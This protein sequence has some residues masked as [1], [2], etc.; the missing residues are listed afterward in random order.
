M[1]SIVP[2]P[3]VKRGFRT[4]V[5]G[6]RAIAV[7]LVLA[8]HAGIPGIS[9]GYVGVDIF[10]VIS[11]FLISTHLLQRLE[12]DGR[13]GF[14]D[15]YARRVRRI[16]PA[17]LTVAVLTAVA[18]MLFYPPLALE[19]VLR[20]G[21]ATI[22]YVPNLWF[23]LQNTDYL[24]DHSP[25]P[26]QHYWSL[27]VEEQFYL[28]W[29][30]LLLVLFLVLRRR[31]WAMAIGM[32]V[33]A[34][35]S[36][37][38]GVLLTGSDQPMAF[39]SLPTRAWELLL[40]G[41][42]GVLLLRGA[43]RVRAWVAALGGWLGIALMFV[44]A[45]VFDADTPFPGWAALPPTVG[46]ALVI[47]FGAEAVRA[48]PSALL[49][50]R[51]MQFLGL[52]SYSL[53]LVH[54]PLLVITQAAVGEENPLPLAQRVALGIGLAVPLAWLLFRFV[55]TP[56]R[57][58]RWL[59]GRR[60]RATLL[61]AL[62]MTVVLI[63]G[64]AVS[65]HWASVDRLGTSTAA[66]S[67]PAFPADPP[68]ATGFVPSNMRPSLAGAAAD[69]PPVFTDGCH[70]D[71]QSESVQDCVYGNPG[72]TADIALFGDS[73]TAQWFPAIRDFTRGHDQFRIRSYTKS[74]CP[75]VSVTVLVKGVPYDACN[76]WRLAVLQHLEADPPEL[77]V[78]SSY[79]HYPLAGVSDAAAGREAW[80][81]GLRQTVQRLRD[82]GSKV[83]I[84]ADTPRLPSQPP[85]CLSANIQDV[86][87]CDTQR[88]WALNAQLA[89]TEKMVAKQTG[90][91]YADLTRYICDA[92]VCPTIVDDIQV[93]RD[94][95][96]LTATFVSYIAPALAPQLTSMLDL[97]SDSAP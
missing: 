93:Y 44:S 6:L 62:G 28:F 50:L 53:Y 20:D 81:D 36:L 35:A 5:Q 60:P 38:A 77:V 47:C 56:L 34:A 72:A 4:D 39:F 92:K 8:Y 84:I 11:G 30:L 7:A 83:L 42:V 46:A 26:Y 45:V 25:S 24:A 90:V 10:F 88:S 17:S 40:G 1:E 29:P 55:E 68:P 59:T 13:I 61:T 96:H 32:V 18:A 71:V 64:S 33:V 43:L 63:M 80:A 95:N 3:S 87:V 9:G 78:I 16:L 51:P 67:A 2:Q 57:S 69:L 19:R 12:R 31:R 49:S 97:G 14:A 58:P 54:W 91:G 22:L 74:S 89:Q 66:A 79:A 86:S 82:A 65:V 85:T 48:G 52:I 70:L 15:F 27:G 94:V 23:A 75:A 21:F 76:R 37:I 73:H 41:I